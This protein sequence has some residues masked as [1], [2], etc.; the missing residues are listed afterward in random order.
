MTKNVCVVHVEK[1]GKAGDYARIYALTDDI[2]PRMATCVCHKSSLPE[3]AH[4]GDIMHAVTY[5]GKFGLAFEPVCNTV[6]LKGG[7]DEWVASQID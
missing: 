2:Q 7:V 3:A 6:E 4:V 5:F 1:M